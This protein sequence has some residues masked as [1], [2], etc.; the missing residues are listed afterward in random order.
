M[1]TVSVLPGSRSKGPAPDRLR[2]AMPSNTASASPPSFT[3][4]RSTSSGSM[5]N[6]A[7]PPNATTG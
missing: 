4:S 7:E 1:R 3:S 5:S 6:G 2:S